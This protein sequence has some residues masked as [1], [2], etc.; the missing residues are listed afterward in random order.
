M[1]SPTGW[2]GAWIWPP[3]TVGCSSTTS[4][5]VS[6]RIVRSDAYRDAKLQTAAA[7]L[8]DLLG[9]D[10]EP[11]DLR[12]TG[13]GGE[14]W[15]WAH[16]LL[17]SNN[18]YRLDR[19]VGGGRRLRLDTGRLGVA[20]ARIDGPADAVGFVALEAAGRIRTFHGWE[21]WETAHFTVDSGGPIDVGV[22]GE[23][24]ALDPP[25]V[26]RVRPGAL[27]VRL[28]HDAPGATGAQPEAGLSAAT[29]SSLLAVAAGR[30]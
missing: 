26:F 4:P 9:P 25:L 21:E 14:E 16:M 24:M 28:A 5:W 1:P 17:V 22:D 30:S 27:R 12:F 2:S 6:A 13:P 10:V 29:I 3:S 20:A 7:L 11:F 15:T 18:P 23:S 19:L 8:P